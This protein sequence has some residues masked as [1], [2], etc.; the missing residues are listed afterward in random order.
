M[1]RRK[2]VKG[3]FLL[4]VSITVSLGLSSVGCKKK[5]EKPGPT[6]QATFTSPD[7]A[8]TK[9][10]GSLSVASDNIITARASQSE[11]IT[12][13]MITGRAITAR[14]ITGRIIT[15][16]SPK[17][18]NVIGNDNDDDEDDILNLFGRLKKSRLSK[19]QSEEFKISC[20]D[21]K[22]KC[23]EGKV[24]KAECSIDQSTNRLIF[25]IKLSDCKEIIDEQKGDYI[26]STGYAKGYLEVSTKVS[27]NISDARFIVAIEDGDSLVKEFSGNK[28]TKRVRAKASNFRA[29]ITGRFIEGE[30]DI[31]FRVVTK[32]SGSYSREDEIGKRKEAYS[33]N[34]YVVELTGK[35]PK[36][37][38]EPTLY[39]SIGGGYSV[40]TTPDV[41]CVEGT[42][43]FKTIKPIK[44]SGVQGYCE[45]GEIEVNNAKM[46]FSSGKVKVS[47]ENQQK[48]Y[49]C[50]ELGGLCKYEPITIAEGVEQKPC[51]VWFKDKDGDGYTDGVTK[52]SCEQPG[53]YVSQAQ[54]GDCDDNDKNINPNTVWF[55]DADKDGYTDGTTK[56]A[57]EKPSDEYVSSATAGDCDDG[58]SSM[59]PARTEICDGK[60]NNCNGQPDEG[61]NVGQS[62]TVGVG[63]CARTGQYVC[64]ADGSGTQCNAIPGTPTPEVCDG[65]DN[66]CDGQPDDGVLLVFYKDTDGDGYTD[67]TTQ[68]GCTAPSGYAL[69][70]TSGDCNDND[71]NINPARAEICDYKDNNCN[72]QV[73]EVDVCGS[74]STFAKTI[75]GSSWDFAHSITQSS[76]GGY[77]VAGWTSSFGAGSYDM[78]VV[79]LDSSG[80][81]VWT[82]TIGGIGD[83]QAWSIIRSSDGNYVVAGWTNSFGSNYDFYVVKLDSSGNI[84]WTKTIGGSGDDQAWSITQSSDGGYVV[85]G[86]TSS[87]GAGGWDF[88]VVKLDSSGNVQWTKTIGGP[89][90]Q[91]EAWSIIQSSDGGY[92]VA[93]WSDSFGAGLRDFY[94]VKLDANGN[95]VWSKTIGGNYGDGAHSIIQS[96]D[97]GYVVVG[98]TESFGAGGW[99]MYIV[100]LDSSG[101]VQWTKTI[102]GPAFFDDA[103]SIIQSS[104][105]GYV[106]SGYTNSFGAGG[107]DFF[108]VKLDSSGNV[109][110]AKTIGGIGDDAWG[111]SIIQS[112]DGGY[113]VVGHTQSFGAGGVDIYVVKMDAN[114]NVCFSQ[115]ITDYSVSS[116][117]GSFSSPS[118][119]AISQSPTVY[120]I[121]PTISYGG[122]VS[123]VCPSA[124]APH[125][126]SVSQDCGFSSAIATSREY[127][128]SYGCSAGGV[129]SRFLIPASMLI[130][131]GWLRKKRKKKK[132]F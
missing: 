83:D 95:V 123:D 127:V 94:V 24:E 77:V 30:K 132:V 20:E 2:E 4:L 97:G 130:V 109:V 28:E 3:L 22:P 13:R 25:D 16:R 93:G 6:G 21:V 45:S 35:S 120:P 84:I 47:V 91:D 69:S 55:K 31:D 75:G 39:M 67:G 66:D 115:N 72:G 23:V 42:F 78:Y 112:S 51:P 122:S 60:D 29:E 106:V 54:T 99:E 107:D 46:E 82:K 74:A 70:A 61:F 131:Y 111:D 53:G 43:N 128:K 49:R 108:V 1:I 71:P 63:E 8:A 14:I 33:Y 98:S 17:F 116:N 105:G 87:F 11:M 40:D 124:P 52:V 57:C 126:C 34:D 76:D 48:E 129:L 18:I 58:D 7:D 15:A 96:S 62:C 103:V 32:I 117:V 113:V 101:N 73:D 36:S 9:T 104:D 119:V 85:A 64:K 50:E 10:F 65:L 68:V 86:R 26:I 59:N 56:V 12:G 121:S 44:S 5:S 125:L 114:G 37:G 80:N 110:W 81:V 89:G 79:K 102:G 38:G 90:S 41:E 100:K 19:K 118:T 27:Q 88:Y 92:V